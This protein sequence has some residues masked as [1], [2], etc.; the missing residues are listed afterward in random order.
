MTAMTK[1]HVPL[2][3]V[4]MN[5]GK[6]LAGPETIHV[7]VTNSCNT[8][9]IT[10]WD[11]SPLLTLGRKSEWKRRR[12]DAAALEE[13]LAD[14]CS[15]GGLRAVIL[16]GMGEPFTHPDIYRMIEVVKRRGLHLTIITN[17]VAA[18]AERVLELGVDQLL[19]GVHGATQGAYEAFHPSFRNGEWDRLLAMLARFREAGRRFKH[20]QVVCEVNADELVDMVRFASRYDAFALNFKLASL[21][22]GTEAARITDAQR[23]RLVRELVPE[24]R[25]VA[26]AHEVT[27]NLD[28]FA[29]QLEAGGEATAP[30]D[31]V[32]CFIGYTYARV[33]VDGTVLYCC[34]TE[35]VVGNLAA[36]RFAELWDGAR[37]NELRAR[38]RRGEYFPSCAQCGKINEN[39][40]LRKRFAKAYGEER[41]RAVTGGRS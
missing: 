19:I 5:E 33:L 23:A 1:K 17:L 26:E 2:P 11:H 8:N 21:R 32:G 34:N 12:I 39:V 25:R 14:A 29:A 13:L 37:W 36:A 20:V 22:G 16:S 9:C 28:V 30:I 7:D 10:C 35:V 6:V 24:A 41:A 27:T 3:L 40:K 31:E 4:G 15:L 38:M 18:D